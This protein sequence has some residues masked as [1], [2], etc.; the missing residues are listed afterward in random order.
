MTP[1]SEP[2][3]AGAAV[4]VALGILA[5]RLAGLVRQRVFAHYFGNG[6]V[7]DAFN[8]AMRI[9]NLLQ[10]L[11]GEGV[12]SA[13]FIPVYS[14][15]LGKGEPE[16]AGRVAGVIGSIL[17]V[18]TTILVAVGVSV[19]PFAID[20]IAPGFE[21]E[22]RLATIQMVR[23]LFPGIGL[24]VMS[25]WCLGILNSHRRFFLSYAAPVV[26]SGVMVAAMLWF[27]QTT[28]G[29]DLAMW[30]SW[31]AVLGSLGQLL[32]QVPSVLA[33]DPHLRRGFATDSPAVNQVFRNLGPVVISRGVVQVSSYVDGMLA[34]L[35][36]AG[37]VAALGYAQTIS[38]LPVS[39]FGMAVSASE[40]PEMA[41]ATGSADEI[42]AWLQG[43]LNAGLRRIAFLVVPSSVA[44][45]TIG[46]TIAATLYQS[47]QF[48]HDDA[49][50]VWSILGGSSVGLLAATMGRLYAS[51]F[52]AL[53][54]TRSPLRFAVIRVA[55]TTSLGWMTSLYLPGWLGLGAAWGVA[56]IAVSSATA[57]WV[58]FY[59]LRRALNGR[60]GVTGVASAVMARLYGCAALGGA[61]GFGAKAAIGEITPWIGGPLVMVAFGLTYL[62]SAH[63]LGLEEAGTLVRGVV[64]RIRR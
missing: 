4:L 20:L 28:S 34:S 23:I 3:R 44:L 12:L 5:S 58:E 42:A 24:L 61:V 63:L 62:G 52:Y 22:K 7:A 41:R 9:P 29:Y 38:T 53:N 10:N 64:R 31:G 56:G 43:R 6:D 25:A 49:V 11:F 50:W 15:L 59:L 39:L 13:S 14:S 17:A 47:G 19:A 51:T 33:V 37:S 30:V 18:V 55:L 27:G 60:I 48:T 35:L 40:L 1:P 32:V 16:E 45:L 57:G 54:D 8:A 21:G 36:P 26:W 46:D 2:R